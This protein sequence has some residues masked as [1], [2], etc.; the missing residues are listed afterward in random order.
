MVSFA[1]WHFDAIRR[2]I[3][4]SS[5]KIW[6][7][8][9]ALRSSTCFQSQWKHFLWKCQLESEY[10]RLSLESLTA[11]LK[12]TAPIP[13]VTTSNR[14]SVSVPELTYEEENALR[15][16]GGYVIKT[17][18]K[19]EKQEDILAAL[20]LITNEEDDDAPADS[21]EWVCT[22]D[23]G[24]LI[25]ITE[26]FYLTLCSIEY[27]IRQLLKTSSDRIPIKEFAFEINEDCEVQFQWCMASVRM[28][29]DIAH[30]LL[31]KI[32][33]TWITIRGYSFVNTI[34]EQYKQE[35]KK[36]TQKSKALR[37]KLAEN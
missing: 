23:R 6:T 10:Q 12:K 4:E 14:E 8:F 5:Q 32:I 13:I 18:G 1:I 3:V 9:H 29:E 15:Y 28:S 34:I 11:L 24:G 25:R 20:K 30:L 7:K 26:E 31:E 35:N 27:A 37:R 17:L 16:V 33:N 36:T 2:V 21:E 22:I 19:K